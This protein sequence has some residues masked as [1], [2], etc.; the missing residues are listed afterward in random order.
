M[1]DLELVQFLQYLL[2]DAFQ[3]LILQNFVRFVIFVVV[4]IGTASPSSA[5]TWSA[6]PLVSPLV[7]HAIVQLGLQDVDVRLVVFVLVV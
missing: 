7:Q 1:S 2:L 5:A 4:A 6:V 3:F